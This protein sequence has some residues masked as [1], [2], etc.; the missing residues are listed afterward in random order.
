MNCIVISLD[1]LRYDHVGAYGNDHIKTPH[2]DA[3]L[4]RSATFERMYV[5][6]YPT[7]PN[8]LDLFLGKT[9]FPYYGWDPFPTQETP[10]AE[11]LTSAGYVTQIIYDTPHLTA[12]G[13]NFEKGFQ[14]WEWIRGQEG[15]PY[16]TDAMDYQ[17]P[18]P[19]KKLRGAPGSEYRHTYAQ[20]M[21]NTR[22]FTKETDYFA[23][24]VFS[25][26]MEWLDSNMGH[27]KFF[28]WIDCF[29]PHEPFEP[30]PPYDTMYD[31]GYKGDVIPHPHYGHVK[32]LYSARELRNIHARYAGEVAFVDRWVGMFVQ[33]LDALGLFEDTLLILCADHGF[34]FGEHG[35]IGK[36]YNRWQADSGD[37]Y[38]EIVR[39]P[40]CILHPKGHGA[41]KRF[42]Q[43]AL[44]ADVRPTVLEALGVDDPNAGDGL[45]LMSLL[46]GKTR[47]HR[48]YAVSGRPLQPRWGVNPVTIT[49]G[50]FS[51][52]HYPEDPTQDKLFDLAADPGQ[53]KNVIRQDLKTAAKLVGCFHEF[54]ED[55]G[56]DMDN[57]SAFSEIPPA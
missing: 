35:L 48:S 16:R 44:P 34:Y 17:W 24:K 11:V 5:G 39:Q 32:Q 42:R 54:L 28:L 4:K 46:K 26:A 22:D 6:S 56:F 52:L 3:L 31:P 30:P 40:F 36:P 12:S 18:A 45:S 15:D 43:L 7:L 23:A 2:L 38:E 9:T 25:R 27:E 57:L 33:K 53:Q 29:D 51:L 20:Y 37:L 10:L 41:G 19:I 14:G 8:R 50:R 55:G 49:S 21:R 47:K 1:S 13:R